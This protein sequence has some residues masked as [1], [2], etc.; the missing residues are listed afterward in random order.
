M[1][2]IKVQGRMI[3]SMKKEKESGNLHSKVQPLCSSIK[4]S[5]SNVEWPLN[6]Y[7]LVTSLKDRRKSSV[8]VDFKSNPIDQS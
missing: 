6:E 3:E 5:D 1:M 4:T 8:Y 7:L 2:R